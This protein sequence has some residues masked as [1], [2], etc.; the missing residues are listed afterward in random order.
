M[1]INSF[2]V[3]NILLIILFAIAQYLLKLDRPK[4]IAATSILL[5]IILAFYLCLIIIICV[6]SLIFKHYLNLFLLPFIF[7]PFV[8]GVF[9]NYKRIHFYT[10]VQNLF[11]VLSLIITLFLFK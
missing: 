8:V 3:V 7:I 10:N 6:K 9:A 2:I 4:L 11:F 1:L 5:S